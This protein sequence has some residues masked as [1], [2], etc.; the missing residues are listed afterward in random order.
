M[1]GYDGH[2]KCHLPHCSPRRYSLIYHASPKVF[3]TGMNFLLIF[4]VVLHS[5][6]F[7]Q[8]LIN[9]LPDQSNSKNYTIW[10]RDILLFNTLTDVYALA[11]LIIIFSTLMSA[12]QIN[13]HGTTYLSA[14]FMLFHIVYYILLLLP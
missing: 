12:Q 2:K 5:K 14:H 13:T 10:A 8:S 7:N 1:S 4:T 3:H 9:Q 6:G 11:N